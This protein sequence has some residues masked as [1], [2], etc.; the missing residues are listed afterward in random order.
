MIS[1]AAGTMGGNAVAANSIMGTTDIIFA[2]IPF[3]LGVA[4]TN[5]VGRLMGAGLQQEAQVAAKSASFIAVVN[6]ALTMTI[7]AIFRYQIA[8]LYT[9]SMEVALWN[10]ISNYP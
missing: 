5:Y 8:S 3:G 7:I 4:T 1:V 2:F 9:V 10:T 6:G